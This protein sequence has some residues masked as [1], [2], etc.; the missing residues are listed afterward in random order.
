VP[1]RRIPKLVAKGRKLV[2]RGVATAKALSP[3][4]LYRAHSLSRWRRLGES[5][6]AEFIAGAQARFEGAVLVDGMWDNPN[7]WIRYALFRAA[8]GSACGRELGVVG[9]HRAAEGR[10]TL[11]RLGISRVVQILDLRGDLAVHRR[12][13]RRL[14]AQTRTPAEILEWSLPGGMPADFVYDGILKRQRAA[15]VDLGDRRLIGYV[16]E[17]LA[18]IASAEALL[19]SD[20]FELI[21]LSH[22][23]NFQFA[24]LAW[25]AVRRGIPV[26]LLY[27]NYG[28]PRFVK[29]VKP[30]DL[31]DTTD[32]PK[33]VDLDSI[34]EARGAALAA[35]GSEYLEQRLGGRTDDIGAR[36]AY[37]KA[38]AYVSRAT[39]VEKFG[40]DPDRPVVGVYASNWFDFPHPCGMS[41]FRDFLD[42]IQATLNVARRQP[43]VN[44]LFKA[45]PCDQWYGGVTLSDLMP[46]LDK[47]GHIQL[48]PIDWNGS[49]VLN[50]V[51]AVVTY[52]GTVGIEAAAAGKPVLIA[53]RGWYHDAG[54]A[55]WP[56]SREE[57]LE[58]LAT[59]W[60]K[61]VDLHV[62]R[63]R[64]QIFAGWYFGRPAWQRGFV[65]TDDTVQ[66][67]I[68]ARIPELFAENEEAIRREL[69]T[70][71]A[72]FASDRR[73]YHT[74]KMGLAD[75][76]TW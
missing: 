46:P 15:I 42:W 9:P 55:T 47:R 56:Q 53:D 48:V 19:D 8:I 33:G 67:P 44:W 52:H 22:A 51:D 32:R 58:A 25:S 60:W 6:L 29:L 20:R 4:S 1:L 26:V 16:T 36:Y 17:A 50:G 38:N 59:D 34:S 37:Q 27:G 45:H 62:T 31:Y 74:F 70:I 13:A 7:Y 18:S 30:A 14:L 73:H 35:V 71:R 49:A 10:R 57:Y 21:L 40:W 24:A 3:A 28:V 63:P 39:L 68:Y 54:F 64:A 11:K 5:I 61:A 69:D 2:R 65:L 75:E 12:E 23:V 66:A 43:R 72:W 76:L 41:H